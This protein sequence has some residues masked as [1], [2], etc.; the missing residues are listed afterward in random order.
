[1][2]NQ[3]PQQPA[4]EP[5]L[6]EVRTKRLVIVSESGEPVADLTTRLGVVELRIGGGQAGLPCEVAL[7]AGEEDVG[8]WSGGIALRANGDAVA[9]WTVT[10]T[11][12]QV[13]VG[14]FGG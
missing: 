8:I 3:E 7:T 1:M 6:A 5:V 14:R 4:P 13:N 9:S 2:P 10:V 11:G 12:Q